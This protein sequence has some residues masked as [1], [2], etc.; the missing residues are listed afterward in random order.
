MLLHFWLFDGSTSSMTLA[1]LI[2][3]AVHSLAWTVAA[4]CL[5][6]G[7]APLAQRRLWAGALFGPLVSS[8]LSM[9]FGAVWEVSPF[10][11]AAPTSTQSL[12]TAGSAA[13]DFAAILFIAI[14]L[15]S[16]L[17]LIRTTHRWS[18][19]ISIQREAQCVQDAGWVNPLRTLEQRID[20]SGVRLVH[21]AAIQGPVALG[22]R[23]ICIPTTMLSLG[24]PSR[25]GIVAHELAHIERRD[26]L[27]FP[28][29]H[30]LES[31]LWMIPSIRWSARRFRQAAE[32]SCDDRA[33]ELTGESRFVARA[34]LETAEAMVANQPPIAAM[35]QA[36]A[37]ARLRR[38]VE[39]HNDRTTSLPHLLVANMAVLGMFAPSIKAGPAV[40]SMQDE[41]PAA[42]T[43]SNTIADSARR[44][45]ELVEKQRQLE[46]TLSLLPP[47][48]T[49]DGQYERDVI[50]QQLRHT[51]A[52]LT[53]L[54]EQE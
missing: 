39:G 13:I 3:L 47:A 18:R 28:L 34:L 17:A 40:H 53:W 25:M 46:E 14:A 16:T 26:G 36:F 10:V 27:W 9:L 1:A 33:V 2:T 8:C 21:S 15:L 5:A 42:S 44:T 19:L 23:T 43:T 54:E 4:A 24:L 32:L 41:V 7:R 49:M 52:E 20:L 29:V 22:R 51:R 38:I 30:G 45:I 31:L 12:P 6:R 11:D 35:A 48:S 50:E 37:V